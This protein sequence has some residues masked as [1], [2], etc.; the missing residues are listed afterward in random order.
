V[1]GPQDGWQ[2][3]RPLD[4]PR[5]VH[6]QVEFDELPGKVPGGGERESAHARDKWEVSEREDGDA[7]ENLRRFAA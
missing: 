7:D 2:R 4:G 5:G 6:E 3:V 1:I